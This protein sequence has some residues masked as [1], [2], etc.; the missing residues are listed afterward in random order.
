MSIWIYLVF[1]LEWHEK[2][3]RVILILKAM[4]GD[5]ELVTLLITCAL[6]NFTPLHTVYFPLKSVFSSIFS[7][8]MLFFSFLLFSISLSVIIFYKPPAKLKQGT[9]R[10]LKIEA[11][12]KGVL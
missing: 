3:N 7:N 11:A 4:K 1:L 6:A 12:T 2:E 10:N 8:S 5:V 9:L